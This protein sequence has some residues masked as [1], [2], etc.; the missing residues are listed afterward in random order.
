[1]HIPKVIKINNNNFVQSDSKSKQSMCIIPL[2]FRKMALNEK[3]TIT[4]DVLGSKSFIYMGLIEDEY[5]KTL[6]FMTPM[7]RSQYDKKELDK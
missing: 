7:H 5:A 1:M 4:I 3:I 2:D 6:D